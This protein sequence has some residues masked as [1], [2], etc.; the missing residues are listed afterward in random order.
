MRLRRDALCVAAE[1]ICAVE[2]I[3]RSDPDLVGTVGQISAEPGASNVI[4][5]QV[6]FTVDVRS[7]YDAKRLS[8]VEDIKQQ[9]L[10]AAASRDVEA[11]IEHP[12]M[13]TSINCDQNISD[14]MAQAVNEHCGTVQQLPSGAGHDTAAMLE[15]TPSGM[16]FVR[17][18]GGIS[19]HPDESIEAHDGAVAVEVL[20]TTL[21]LMAQ[22]TKQTK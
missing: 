16:L 18:K 7:P 14:L 2:R 11:H 12:H 4:P 8:A 19:H 1:S 22:Q 3:C 10:A 13:E 9:V 5:G 20:I 15:M 6:K 21:E 17:C